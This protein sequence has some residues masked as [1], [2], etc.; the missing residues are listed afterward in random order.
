MDVRGI[1]DATT[2]VVGPITPLAVVPLANPGLWGDFATKP[3]YLQ[4]HLQI[5]IS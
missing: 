2:L 5:T 4:F 3:Y 1:P